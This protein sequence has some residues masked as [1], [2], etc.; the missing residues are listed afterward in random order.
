MDLILRTAESDDELYSHSIGH[1]LNSSCHEKADTETVVPAVEVTGYNADSDRA[2]ISVSV[3]EDMN[4]HMG[5][6]FTSGSAASTI[7]H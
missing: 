6:W 3:A 7:S 5:H 1:N 2:K 4:T